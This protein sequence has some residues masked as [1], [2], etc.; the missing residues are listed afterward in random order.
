APQPSRQKRAWMEEAMGPKLTLH[1]IN[2]SFV[3]EVR[4][5]DLRD[6]P[7]PAVVAEIHRAMDLYGVLI[8]RD[9]AL[10]DDQQLAF[11]AAL[12]TLEAT[13]AT[14]DAEKHRLR[15]QQLGDISNLGPDGAILAADSR[16]RMFNLGNQLWH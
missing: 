5:L 4:D 12:G 11:G 7:E 14:A 3:A 1:A 16:R 10:N 8:F 13:R 9:Q 2:P 15:H 6:T